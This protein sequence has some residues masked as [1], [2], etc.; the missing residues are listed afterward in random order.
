MGSQTGHLAAIAELAGSDVSAVRSSFVYEEW[1][2]DLSTGLIELGAQTLAMHDMHRS[3]CGIVELIRS[4][5]PVDC[6]RIL[7]ALEEASGTSASFSFA[8]TIHARDN[9]RRPVY[10]VGRSDLLEGQMGVIHGVFAFIR[11]ECDGDWGSPTNGR[12]PSF[13]G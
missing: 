12:R 6:P 4:Y 11:E 10:C 7:W 3:P 8:T 13:L 5:D 9:L 2:A 1:G